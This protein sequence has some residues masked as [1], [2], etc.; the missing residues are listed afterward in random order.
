MET[1]F[2]W[3]SGVV[4][5]S[6]GYILTAHQV[7][8]NAA[9][10]QVRLLNGPIIPA[11]LEGIDLGRGIALLSLDAVGLTTLPFR[12]NEPL[13]PSDKVIRWGYGVVP[14]YGLQP[15]LTPTA[16]FGRITALHDPKRPVSAL[17]PDGPAYF[18][19]R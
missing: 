13:A 18:A 1:E 9:I 4:I 19:R 2:G 12:A 14:G 15:S 5:R 16:A 7:V 17:V 10:I 8:E 11:K 3:G 6:D